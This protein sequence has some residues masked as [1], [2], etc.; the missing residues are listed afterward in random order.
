MSGELQKKDSLV[1]KTT[2]QHTKDY[3]SVIE[4]QDSGYT[5]IKP[6]ILIKEPEKKIQDI[7]KFYMEY[8]VPLKEILPYLSRTIKEG[9]IKVLGNEKTK[10]DVIYFFPLFDNTLECNVKTGE[11]RYINYDGTYSMFDSETKQLV[12]MRVPLEDS[13]GLEDSS[14]PKIGPYVSS[15]LEVDPEG[16]SGPGSSEFSAEPM[17][18]LDYGEED[19]EPMPGL[20][21]EEEDEPS[22]MEQVDGGKKKYTKRYKQ[23]KTKRKLTKRKKLKSFRYIK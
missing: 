1:S 17:P 2:I 20:D 14:S 8:G 11:F 6:T 15:G 21:N 5:K 23:N 7:I 16:S 4:K 18:G 3:F 19:E 13:T 22:I 12:P 9:P 10:Y